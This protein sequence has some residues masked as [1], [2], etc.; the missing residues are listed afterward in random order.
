VPVNS[1]GACRIRYPLGT[2]KSEAGT[3]SRNFS[4]A[5][6]DVTVLP[7]GPAPAT[8]IFSGKPGLPFFATH[9]F[10]TCRRVGNIADAGL[11]VGG[12]P[13]QMLQSMPH[14][15]PVPTCWAFVSWVLGSKS[16]EGSMSEKV[17]APLRA[18]RFGTSD[19][20]A[21][22]IVGCSRYLPVWLTMVTWT[23]IGPIVSTRILAPE[24]H[25]FAVIC[26][27]PAGPAMD[28]GAAP[29][30]DPPGACGAAPGW[31]DMERSK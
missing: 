16:T 3:R 30:G 5:M 1:G 4:F 8:S 28:G 9:T 23:P 11:A 26:P 15:E 13:C 18:P 7:F 21:V 27:I 10:M 2:T 20:M 24:S 12:S 14:T 6:V 22:F 25:P 17:T 31:K 29:A 19:R